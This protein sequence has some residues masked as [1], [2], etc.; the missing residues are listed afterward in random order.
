VGQP[1]LYPR[2]LSVAGFSVL[3]LAQTDPQELHT[4]A[5]RAFAAVVEGTVTLP[6]TAE[7]GL[8]E[9]AEAHQLMGTRTS[10]GKLL[11]RVAG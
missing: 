10:T 7:F 2:A 11:L 4:L 5:E 6:V 9:A 3:T 8:G 1:E